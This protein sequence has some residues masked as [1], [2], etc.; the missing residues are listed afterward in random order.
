MV[1]I[2]LL[3]V[4][5]DCVAD[6]AIGVVPCGAVNCPIPSL[7]LSYSVNID[8]SNASIDPFGIIH[9]DSNTESVVGVRVNAYFVCEH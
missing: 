4:D 7:E 9:S 5:S 8:E 2:V 6:V 3:H 1:A